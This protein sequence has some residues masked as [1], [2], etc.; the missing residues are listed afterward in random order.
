MHHNYLNNQINVFLNFE[1]VFQ[2][3]APSGQPAL[4]RVDLPLCRSRCTIREDRIWSS[5]VC[6]L[7]P[8]PDRVSTGAL[9][10]GRTFREPLCTDDR[11]VQTHYSLMVN[12]YSTQMLAGGGGGGANNFKESSDFHG[13]EGTH[14]HAPRQLLFRTALGVLG[15]A[16]RRNGRDRAVFYTCS[17]SLPKADVRQS[18]GKYVASRMISKLANIEVFS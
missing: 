8:V 6:V 5:K 13:P 17:R 7:R 1:S 15:L 10:S 14:R 11:F 4:S 12:S 18:H 2:R 16:L 3:N 9:E